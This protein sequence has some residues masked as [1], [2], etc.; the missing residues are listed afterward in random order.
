MSEQTD[1]RELRELIERERVLAL[2]DHY[3]TAAR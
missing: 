1:E 3:V 2:V